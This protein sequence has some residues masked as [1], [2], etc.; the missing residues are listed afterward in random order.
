[1]HGC[2]KIRTLSLSILCLVCCFHGAFLVR[3]ILNAWRLC[4]FANI[5]VLSIMHIT[6][7]FASF[8][9]GS[10]LLIGCMQGVG[11]PEW[12]AMRVMTL[13][14]KQHMSQ[15]SV[16]GGLF[17][18]VRFQRQLVIG[19]ASSGGGNPGKWRWNLKQ[20]VVICLHLMS[21]IQNLQC[22]HMIILFVDDDHSQAQNSLA[23]LCL[24]AA[25]ALVAGKKPSKPVLIINIIITITI[26]I[27]IIKAITTIIV[28]I[29]KIT[30]IIVLDLKI[31]N[32]RS[33]KSLRQRGRLWQRRKLSPANTCSSTRLP[34]LSLWSWSSSS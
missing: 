31:L 10:Q 29:N 23:L 9:S 15:A 7:A 25:I 18:S 12:L 17:S 1:M 34:S 11:P 32:F 21:S 27:V 3:R 14:K 28:M 5:L 4:Y 19:E 33:R 16:T 6:L 24:F 26:T 20:I 13:W 8:L 22:S 30:T 2:C